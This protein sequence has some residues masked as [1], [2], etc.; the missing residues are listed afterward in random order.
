M[1]N[2]RLL[3]ENPVKAEFNGLTVFQSGLTQFSNVKL[4]SFQSKERE[5]K[6]LYS[7]ESLILLELNRLWKYEVDTT[8]TRKK[9]ENEE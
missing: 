9:E 5:S 8:N 6:C 7:P 1:T 2:Y 4:R 3:T